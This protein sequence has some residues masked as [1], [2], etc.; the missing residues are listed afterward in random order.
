MT[1]RRLPVELRPVQSPSRYVAK[2]RAKKRAAGLCIYGG[3]KEPATCGSLCREHREQHENGNRR[4]RYRAMSDLE[5]EAEMAHH[6]RAL[7]LLG[8]ENTRRFAEQQAPSVVVD[9][10]P[11]FSERCEALP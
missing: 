6:E 3:C 4:R 5:L 2:H 10:L 1:A 9:E 8:E 7:V 11:G